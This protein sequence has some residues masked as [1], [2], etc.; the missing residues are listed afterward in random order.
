MQ[1]LIPFSGNPLDRSANERRDEAWLAKQL[2]AAESRFL[3]FWRLNVLARG[4]EQARLHWLDARVQQ[5]L[6]DGAAP[7]LLGMRDGVAHFA[8]DVSALM[9]PLGRL[10]IEDADFMD[11]RRI[12]P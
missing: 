12:A 1:E 9:D 10:G 2:D 4:T 7:L 3:A 6:E 11:A 8:V 5:H